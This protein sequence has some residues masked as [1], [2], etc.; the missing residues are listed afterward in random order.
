[1][2]D[3]IDEMVL[4]VM[5]TLRVE[6]DIKSKSRNH[7]ISVEF[8][9]PECFSCLV[10]SSSAFL[11]PPQ[12][13]PLF[14]QVTSYPTTPYSKP[15]PETHNEPRKHL[16]TACVLSRFR[17]IRADVSPGIPPATENDP[18]LASRTMTM[19]DYKHIHRVGLGAAC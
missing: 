11:D 4:Q 5:A 15:F 14:I 18:N 8:R 10:D 2:G 16:S 13:C 6:H 12:Q 9:R 1:M 19:E 3:E 7:V 17:L